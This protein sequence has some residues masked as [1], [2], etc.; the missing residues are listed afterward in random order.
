MASLQELLAEC[1]LT[2][3]AVA[4]QEKTAAAA[5]PSTDEV[6]RVLENLGLKETGQEKTASATEKET[7]GNDMSLYEMYT[8]AFDQVEPTAEVIE[9]VAS[10]VSTENS[11][12]LALGELVGEYFNGAVDAYAGEFEK[13]A[14]DLEAAA[15]KGTVPT[16]GL[17]SGEKGDPHLPVNRDA[18]GGEK[19]TVM[20][21][22]DSPYAFGPGKLLQ[23]RSMQKAILKKMRAAT[24]GEVK[25]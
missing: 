2:D 24:I 15:G 6:D 10:D 18:S 1:N 9:K 23:E 7:G 14:A 5:K 17:P 20:T 16:A 25:Q 4:G 3:T 8:K 12:T 13:F 22:S 19:L 21:H 11:A